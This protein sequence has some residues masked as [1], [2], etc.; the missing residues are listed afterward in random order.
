MDPERFLIETIRSVVPDAEVHATDLN[1]GGDHWHV[2]IVAASFE[3]QRSFQRQ[4][5]VLAAFTPH[6]QSG[7]VHALDLKCITPAELQ[8]KDGVLPKP[9]VPHQRGE[10]DH[11]G[12]W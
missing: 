6:I 12:A 2:V 1:G 5:P 9:F 7:L 3:G 11:P 8:E 10:G 4:R